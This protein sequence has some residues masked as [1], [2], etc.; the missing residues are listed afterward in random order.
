MPLT[1]IFCVVDGVQIPDERRHNKLTITCSDACRTRLNEIRREKRDAKYCRQC[2]KPCTP[3]ERV[4]YQR[5]RRETF[6][7]PKKGRPAVKKDAEGT[8]TGSEEGTPAQ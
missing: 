6:P 7:A 8:E 5:W 1:P 3:E 4:L 2:G